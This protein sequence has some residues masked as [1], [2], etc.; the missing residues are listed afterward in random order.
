M[1]QLRVSLFGRFSVS[2]DQKPL[3]LVEGGKVQELFCYLLLQR[4]RPHP[5]ETLATLLWHDQSA[6]QSKNYL[7]KALWRLQTSVEAA[8][9]D[10]FT[11]LLVE[12]DWIQFN[13]DTP[14]WLD[15]VQFEQAFQSTQ[16]IPGEQ[17]PAAAVREVCQVVDLYRGELLQGCYEEWCL[18]N[19]ERLHTMYLILLDKLMRACQTHQ[20]YEKGIMYG[21]RILQNDQ[22]RECTHRQLMRLHYLSGNRTAA[23]RQYACCVQILQQELGVAPAHR[24]VAVYEQILADQLPQ[25]APDAAFP[26]QEIV[27]KQLLFHLSESALQK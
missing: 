25:I 9:G 12:P 15:V 16:D 13:T 4:H 19:R 24:T 26:P 20:E 17:L 27:L 6:N 8:W 14:L 21:L 7:R 22:A 18:F 3:H 2:L 5:R 1:H 11:L 10:S 23:L